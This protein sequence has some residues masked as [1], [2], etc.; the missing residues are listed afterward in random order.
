MSRSPFQIRGVVE[1]F[2]GAFYT[3]PQR[4]DLIRFIGRHGYNLY[5]Y[6]PKND[7]QHRMR[8]WEP[9]PE[10]VMHQF[11]RTVEI[12]KDSGVDFCYAI[13]FG[14]P[15]NYA[16]DADFQVVTSKLRAFYDRGVR[17]YSVLL[18]DIPCGFQHEANRK[19][20]ERYSQAHVSLCNRL[21]DWLQSL[22]PACTLLVCPTEYH[23]TAP[24]G[25][26]IQE[27]G[28]DL[29]PEIDL[30]YSGPAICSD[31]ISTSA[32]ESFATAARRAPLI[33]DN[34]P[35]ND[36]RMR[37]EMHLGP[38]RG[39]DESLY[40]AT[41]GIVVN[42]MLQPEAS[43][44]PLLTFADYFKDPNG[45]D[46]W[47]SWKA[48]L[49]QIGGD[50]S[51]EPLMRFAENCLDSCL[52]QA[53]I[54][55]LQRLTRALLDALERGESPSGSGAVGALEAY[56]GA[57]DEA[58]YLLKYRMGN[59][60]LRAELLPW[61]ESLEDW[62]WTAKR[63]LLTLKLLE[64]GEDY[65]LSLAAMEETLEATHANSRR[66]AGQVLGSLAQYVLDR[67]AGAEPRAH[68]VEGALTVSHAAGESPWQH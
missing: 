9:Y 13:S 27:L 35:V 33:W 62:V 4:D 1:G 61:I 39:R 18:D 32:V 31:R 16:S 25:D 14:V 57:M 8:W 40:R 5:V 68:R 36:L 7:R 41:K 29:H 24:F 55:Q 65:Q 53:E 19:A 56:L 45:Y 26:Y 47:C 11:G 37:S 54:P 58:C 49:R 51:F 34:Y 20:Y 12:A 67:C 15:M 23:G 21:F 3:F 22:D 50:R 44:I 48:A 10:D 60:A 63:A 30:F 28:E 6:G 64:Q 59:L 52:G 2:Y 46:P 38:V 17:V 42:T 43:K 66:T